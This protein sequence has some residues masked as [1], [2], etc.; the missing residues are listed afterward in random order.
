MNRRPH[1]VAVAGL[2]QCGPTSADPRSIPEMVLAAVEAA[3]EDAALG[4]N[5]FD[6]AVTASV[7]LFDGLTASN[8]AVT[9][10]VGAVMRPETRIA[11]D[12][13]CAAIHAACQIRAG[14]YRTV[15]VAAHGKASMAPLQALQMW[16]MEPIFLQPLGADFRVVAALEARLLAE[17][18]PGAPERWAELVSRRRADAAPGGVAA[19]VSKEDVL[20]SPILAS[21]LTAAMEAPP[22]DA[23]Y[24]VVLQAGGDQSPVRLVGTGYDLEVHAPGDRLLGTQE[25]LARAVERARRM[26]GLG[27]QAPFG[28]Y[29]LSCRYPHEEE[30]V[31]DALGGTHGA[32]VSPK[33]GL[34]AGDAPCAAGLGRLV[35]AVRHLRRQPD[36]GRALV[37][38]SWGP[39]GQG[40][41]VAI[42]EAR[43]GCAQ[44]EDAS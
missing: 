19:P 21:P 22:A 1:T 36:L 17:R 8:V 44:R 9:E 11:G 31:L 14:A 34:F 13:L 27:P 7:D 20:G 4:W 6:A 2:G 35:E 23:A 15:L 24:A 39:A 3:L 12:G 5:D 26:A 28:L 42:V 38:G 30:I 37:H 41:A 10:V 16:A 32:T 29:E 40:Q 18:D 25:G 33:G 43:P